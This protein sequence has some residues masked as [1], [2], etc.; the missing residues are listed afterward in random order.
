[1]LKVFWYIK[2]GLL[3]QFIS[4]YLHLHIF[5]M[6]VFPYN[7]ISQFKDF[8]GCLQIR[9][10]LVNPFMDPETTTGKAFSTFF[11]FYDFRPVC[12]L[13]GLW[14]TDTQIEDFWHFHQI[15]R[16]LS[17]VNSFMHVNVSGTE[18]FPFI[19]HSQ[20]FKM[21]PLSTM[22]PSMYF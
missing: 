4:C 21:S 5:S 12:S 11:T 17:S 19:S 9:F 14:M 16:F 6:G 18:G 1:M 10:Y 3:Y 7:D 20:T 15:D 13:V 8:W 2:H 22:G